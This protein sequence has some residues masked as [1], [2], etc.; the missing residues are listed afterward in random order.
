MRPRSLPRLPVVPG[1]AAPGLLAP[2]GRAT[3]LQG[4]GSRFES[5]A[6]HRPTGHSRVVRRVLWDHE[7]GG[8]SLLARLRF[9][10]SSGRAAAARAAGPRIQPSG[11]PD[12]E[13]V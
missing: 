7:I 8:S 2:I 6:V 3:P 13:L 10:S 12:A 5:G 9:S 4:E 11:N 1:R